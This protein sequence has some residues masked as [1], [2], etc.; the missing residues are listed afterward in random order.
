[1]AENNNLPKI[2]TK[3]P[4]L[5]QEAGQ[6]VETPQEA[7]NEFKFENPTVLTACTANT[8]SNGHEWTPTLQL[9]QCPGCKGALLAIKMD[10][11]P[12][13]NEPCSKLRLRA[14]HLPKGG[15]ITPLCRG[16]QTL[17]DTHVIELAYQ[18]YIQEQTKHVVR[19]MPGK[20]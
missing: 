12:I 4:L 5:P 19:E 15:A 11:C 10:Q 9:T 17:A 3:L 20:V 2:P 14:D 6:A 18:H 13:C 8:C 7:A 16:S 1:M